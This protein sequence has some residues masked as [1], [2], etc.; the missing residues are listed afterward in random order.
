MICRMDFDIFFGIS[1]FDPRC[2]FCMG[3]SLCILADFEN[4]LISRIYDVF[5]N[6]FLHRR[7][8]NDL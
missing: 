8:L 3:Y 2:G 6:G 1:N 7:T 5:W 4:G